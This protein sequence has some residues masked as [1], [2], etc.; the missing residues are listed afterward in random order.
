MSE[1]R[2]LVCDKCGTDAVQIQAWVDANTQEYKGETDSD[3]AW[4]D[5]CE[6]ATTLSLVIEDEYVND[7]EAT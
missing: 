1:K 6:E 2:I 5:F 7:V 3:E 4:C